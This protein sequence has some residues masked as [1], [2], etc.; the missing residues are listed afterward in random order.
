MVAFSG[1]GVFL[2][3]VFL[4]VCLVV[5][6]AAG[7][8]GDIT[9]S[10]KDPSGK[11]GG[12]I[13]GTTVNTVLSTPRVSYGEN[14]V[15]GTLRITGKKDI[16]VPV[17]PGNRVLVSLPPGICYM[18]PPTA[19]NYRN[20][21]EWPEILDGVKNQVHNSDG[22]PGIVFVSGTP[23][24]ITLEAGNVDK[25]GKV[26]VIDILYNKENYSAVRV[27]RLLEAV[28]EY[29]DNPDE[30]V[31]RLDFFKKLADITLPF[32][33]CPLKLVN[34]DKPFN[35]RFT[36]VARMTPQEIDKIKP[37]VDSGVIVGHQ[38]GFL[39]PDDYITR[40]QAAN[41]VGKLYPL[42]DKKIGFQDTVP[43]WAVGIN[44]AV[45]K[46]IVV[47]YPD[48]TFKPDQFITK[49]EVLTLLQRTL[50]SYGEYR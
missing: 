19:E 18:R 9:I 8:D 15:L 17:Q 21:V 40:A 29:E 49:A 2:L 26:M 35:E 3:M 37:L 16:S 45:A 5:P 4:I 10:V 32:S 22:K 20:Y 48:N 46:G 44:A 14:R 36:D 11:V 39:K 34:T 50:E 30:N 47:G 1:R 42:S 28:R 33:S 13:E 12:N 7:A 23:H 31:T 6:T 24:S 43:E 41:L 27:S 38:G 25:S